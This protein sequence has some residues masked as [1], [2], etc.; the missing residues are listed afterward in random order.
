MTEAMKGA[1]KAMKGM[2]A[3]VNPIAM[4][5]I[6]F[7]FEKQSEIMDSKQV[8]VTSQLSSIAC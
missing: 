5:R 3:K 4:Q 7:E 8:R 1:A 2:N 6:L